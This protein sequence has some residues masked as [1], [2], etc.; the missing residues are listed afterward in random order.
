ML[1]LK[2]TGDDG[3]DE[4]IVAQPRDILLFERTTKVSFYALESSLSMAHV[5]KIA[6]FAFKR[7]YPE[8]A[9]AKVTE[10][11]EG[12]DVLL[13]PGDDEDDEDPTRGEA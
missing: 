10:L 9:P 5:Y 11:E 2:I 1:T 8:L 3:F 6:F 7:T 13:V 12:Y 4:T